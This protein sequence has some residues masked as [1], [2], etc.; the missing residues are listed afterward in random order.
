MSSQ[1]AF[2]C[3]PAPVIL[4]LDLLHEWVKYE[5]CETLRACHA[6]EAKPYRRPNY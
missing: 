3:G 2:K 4:V 5:D 1:E 6:K